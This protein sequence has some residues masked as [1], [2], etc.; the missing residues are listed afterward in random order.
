MYRRMDREALRD[1]V[2]IGRIEWL[3]HSLERMMERGISRAFAQE[4]LLSG[5]AIEDY[6]DDNPYPSALYFGWVEN[7][8]LHVVAAYD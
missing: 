2:S 5:D 8:P 3:K 7:N 4:I 6:P 1:A